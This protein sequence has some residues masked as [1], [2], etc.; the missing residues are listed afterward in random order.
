[1][2]LIALT[3]NHG[4]PVMMADLLISSPDS[5]GAIEI[6]TFVKG[7]GKMFAN[8]EDSKPLGLKQKLYV[9][10]DRLCV[11]LGGRGDQMWSFLNRLNAIYGSNDFNDADFLKFIE[12]YPMDESNELIAILLKS[13]EVDGKTNFT[14]RSVGKLHVLNNERYSKVIAGGSG[15]EQ[16]IDLIKTNPRFYTNITNTDDLLVSNLYLISHWLAQEISST[17]PLLNY[18]GAGYEMIIFENGR[19]VKLQEYT[20]VLFVGKFGKGIDLEVAPISTMMI[21]YQDDV[22]IIRA[23]AN[24]IEKIFAV[25]SI[26]DERNSIEVFDNEPKHETLLM[27]YVLENVD[28]KIKVTPTIV[29]P[30]NKNQFYKSPIV[31]KRVGDKLEIHKNPRTDEY[32]LSLVT[33]QSQ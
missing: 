30:R 16:F 4:Y 28:T 24:N 3:V 17:E 7:T 32:V 12:A 1:M 19:F 23:F 22:L 14:V 6:P 11:A 20:V 15:A 18:W 27:T 2:T 25:P 33:K 26:V 31:F 13:Q 10:N 21:N 5:D 9:I 8:M 29:Y